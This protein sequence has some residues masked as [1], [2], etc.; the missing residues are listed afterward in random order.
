MEKEILIGIKKGM[1]QHFQEDWKVVPVT[2][3]D[4]S[5]CVVAKKGSDKAWIGFG[6]KKGNRPELINYKELGY[7][8]R[9]VVEVSGEWVKN[10]KVGEHID[11]KDLNDTVVDVVG[12]SKG[13][14]FSGVVKRFDARG[15]PKTHGQSDRH[16][17]VG[18]IGAQTPGKVWKGQKMPGRM[19]V[20]RVK[21]KNLKVLFV[22]NE[23]REI[24]VVGHVPGPKKGVLFL[25]VKKRVKSNKNTGE[26]SKAEEKLNKNVKED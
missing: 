9:Y 21:V 11:I 8:P 13:R 5:S 15:G 22:D 16:R 3:I 7:V 17:A 23:K 19:G 12:I 1:T 10:Y 25:Y 6:R 26:K 4:L 14:G 2:I 20:R 24:G 18:S